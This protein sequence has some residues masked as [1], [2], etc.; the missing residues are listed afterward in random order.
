LANCHFNIANLHIDAGQNEA[1][2][3]ALVQ[4]RKVQ[5]GLV[6]DFPT[7]GRFH[8]DLARV[9]GQLGAFLNFQG[10]PE[11]SLAN[12][13]EARKILVG[14][15]RDHPEVINYRIDLELTNYHIG[16]RHSHF[17]RYAQALDS[18]KQA[19]D[20][21]ERMVTENA[22]DLRSRLVLAATWDDTGHVLR[23]M[24]RH[25]D[26]ATAY[27]QAIVNQQRSH[28]HTEADARTRGECMHHLV[29]QHEDLAE[30]YVR[31]NRPTD[32]INSLIRAG[33]TLNRQPKSAFGQAYLEAR[34]CCR[35][36]GLLNGK[37]QTLTAAEIVQRRELVDRALSA[38]RRGFPSSDRGFKQLNEDKMFDPL[39]G[40]AE[41]QLILLDLAFPA[42]PL[43]P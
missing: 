37:E 19:R 3:N 15:V 35:L 9:Y 29:T 43:K 33:E 22:N 20:F 11:E 36:I 10:R 27:E 12:L 5:E 31:L 18:L 16:C 14:L 41:F 8:A 32:A 34:I 28:D 42:N 25:S 21:F 26:A 13:E 39:R 17:G 1:I 24:Q 23:G 38:I 4:A 40:N 30:T 2:M 6:H 7:V